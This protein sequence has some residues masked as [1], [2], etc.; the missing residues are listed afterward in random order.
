M[1]GNRLGGAVKQR[2]SHPL[3]QLVEGRAGIALEVAGDGQQRIA[4]I[5]GDPGTLIVNCTEP[6]GWPGSRFCPQSPG[7]RPAHRFGTIHDRESQGLRLS[8][9]FAADHRPQ[10][11]VR[12]PHALRQA[13]G[14]GATG[15]ASRHRRADY[16]PFR[17]FRLHRR[18]SRDRPVARGRVPRRGEPEAAGRGLVPLFDS[19]MPGLRRFEAAAGKPRRAPERHDHF[20][21][22]PSPARTRAQGLPGA[23][24]D[25]PRGGDRRP[26]HGR[27]LRA[28]AIPA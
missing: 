3:R 26:D 1:V 28:P 10:L 19:E 2:L 15:A 6:M 14:A 24:V 22:R 20:G 9:R 13:A 21:I 17:R 12:S 7:P 11:Q 16:P 4:Q 23:G 5:A 25:G 8:G 27:D 18:I